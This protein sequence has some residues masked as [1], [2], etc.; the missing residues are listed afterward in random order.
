MKCP[1]CSTMETGGSP[2][3][4][5]DFLERAARLDAEFIVYDDGFRGRTYR[6]ADVA[7]MANALR[8]RFRAQGIGKGDAVVVWSESRPGW[9]AALWACLLDGV[10]V[11]PVD[12]QSS[13]TLFERIA[14]KS[15]AKLT[16]L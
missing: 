4:L 11:V 13:K 1:D 8:V 2:T 7:G 16:L 6:Y 10:V 9:V 5:V 14:R 3:Q 12:P 15:Q